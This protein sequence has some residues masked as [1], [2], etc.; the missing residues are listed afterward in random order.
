MIK[1]RIEKKDRA[2]AVFLQVDRRGP[3]T[4][5][6]ASSGVRFRNLTESG[7]CSPE[8]RASRLCSETDA[9]DL[10]A[11]PGP[12]P[13]NWKWFPPK[14]WRSEQH[15][16]AE[17]SRASVL[18]EFGGLAFKEEGHT[19]KPT[20]WGYKWAK[21]CQS[22]ARQVVADWVAALAPRLNLS[23]LI[24]TQLT[25]VEHEWNGLLTYD[26][27]VKCERALRRRLSR[28]LG[29]AVASYRPG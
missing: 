22:F 23:A 3:C 7:D 25:D 14:T 28:A 21:N 15:W 6:R 9:I 26:R 8:G 24:Y 13:N 2:L 19:W 29:D 4:V 27:H 17:P 20:G 16:G 11:Y 12:Q 1:K 18:G 10:H 5:L